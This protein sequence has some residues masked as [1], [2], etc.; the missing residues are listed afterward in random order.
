MTMFSRI[1]VGVDEGKPSADGV[2][3]AARLAHEYHGE[4]ILAHAV[5]WVP[6]VA[7]VETGTYV[8][9]TVMIDGL[10]SRGVALL[11]AAAA[12]AAAHGTTAERRNLDGEPAETLLETAAAEL[13]TAIVLGTHGRA[14]LGRLF[15]GSTT[16]AVLRGSTIPVLAIGPSAHTTP[17]DRRC[18][19]RVIVAVDGS[20]PADAA[21]EASIEL[22]A[23]GRLQLTFCGVAETEAVIGD[24]IA[25]TTI[26]EEDSYERARANVE[27][28]VTRARERGVVAASRVV[29][30]SPAPS[31][32]R[33]AHDPNV[34]L[35]VAGSHGR[36]G[37][38]RFLLG[39]VAEALVRTSP[40]PVLVVRTAPVTDKRPLNRPRVPGAPAL[41]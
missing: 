38:S 17:D 34:D 5:D 1:L 41:P 39:S 14:G 31:I 4:L 11:E 30:G 12:I 15:L 10:R 27:R 19:E 6:A 2:A 36:R 13:C 16:E 3:L 26:V 29:E 9:P 35:I 7:Q 25:T 32:V 20:A 28:A 21:V 40:V 33:E 8:D 23:A 24:D 18:F 22:A 37:V